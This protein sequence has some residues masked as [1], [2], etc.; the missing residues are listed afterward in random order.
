MK[1]HIVQ[2]IC[3]TDTCS[4]IIDLYIYTNEHLDTKNQMTA[5]SLSRIDALTTG[6]QS[7]LNC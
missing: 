2:K 5:P 4:A 7:E 3:I 6:T 1:R